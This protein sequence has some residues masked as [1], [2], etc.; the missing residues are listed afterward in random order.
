LVTAACSFLLAAVT[1]KW[2]PVDI[3]YASIPVMMM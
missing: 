1:K 2:P 3:S